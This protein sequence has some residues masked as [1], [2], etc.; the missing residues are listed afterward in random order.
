VSFG[1]FGFRNRSTEMSAL[2]LVGVG[3]WAVGAQTFLW[4]MGN[5]K[6]S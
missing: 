6:N 4:V 2:G 3:S 5:Q 1:K